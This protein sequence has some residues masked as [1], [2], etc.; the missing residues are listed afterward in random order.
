MA[1]LRSA[2]KRIRQ[3]IKRRARNR[4]FRGRARSQVRIAVTALDEG[5]LEAAR[6]ETMEAVSSLDKAASKGVLH[7]NNAS[8][9]KGRLMKRLAALE[10]P[11]K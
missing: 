2:K 11:K 7:K 1:T 3:N 8:R 10:N 6:K 4:V 9:R 5:N